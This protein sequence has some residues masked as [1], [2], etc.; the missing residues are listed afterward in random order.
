[1]PG[2]T[3]R[4][5]IL[6]DTHLQKRFTHAQ[7]A[8]LALAGGADT[9][10]Y[11]N[12][13]FVAEKDLEDLRAIRR[14]KEKYDFHFLINDS[15]DLALMADADGCHGGIQDLPAEIMRQKFVAGGNQNPVI[16][17]TVHSLEELEMLRGKELSYIGVGPV[18]GTSSKNTGLP[19]LGLEK[20]A[21]ICALSPFPVI[22]IGNIS[23]ATV[24]TVMA[25]GASGIA[26]L[27]AVCLSPDPEKAV[28]A[29]AEILF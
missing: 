25:A 18:F 11:R 17:A 7:L 4:L 8:E 27:G 1:M 20:L 23:P 14:L 21:E 12:K 26:V 16:G 29:F 2:F 15:P 24:S 10:Q 28:R 19:A 5:H 6:T 3:G 13:N 9:I 22:A